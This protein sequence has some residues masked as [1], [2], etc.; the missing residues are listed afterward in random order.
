MPNTPAALQRQL[1]DRIKNQLPSNIA[2]PAE[3]ASLLDTSV[4]S[5]YRRISG[6]TLLNL[7]ELRD[8]CKKF[9]LSLDQLFQLGEES[10]LFRGRAMDYQNF[11]FVEYLQNSIEYLRMLNNAPD[12]ILYY[13]NRDI[14]IFY[15]FGYPSL[16]LFK[17]HFWMRSIFQSPDY[18]TTRF[19]VSDTNENLL[20]IGKTLFTEYAKLPGVE[21]WN[22]DCINSTL[23]QVE[24]YRET[25]IFG[26]DADI[27]A[28]YKD[29]ENLLD[30]IE[31]QAAMAVKLSVD[32]KVLNPNA[33]YQMFK[34][35]FLLGD[36]TLYGKAGSMESAFVNH[37]VLNYIS[38]SDPRFCEY[39]LHTM[40]NLISRSALISGVNEKDRSKFFYELRARLEHSR[41]KII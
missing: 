31:K 17:H 23:M 11:E 15:H 7:S 33:H 35:E 16:A 24:Y 3:L 21:I 26:S 9:G 38:T 29:I 5:A 22:V 28:V 20:Q 40:K 30:H 34:N 18:M 36:N 13:T 8:V 39:T 27:E 6:K 41:S 14:P 32:G 10:Y 12:K 4:D 37:N 2:L 25:K 19:K 1:F